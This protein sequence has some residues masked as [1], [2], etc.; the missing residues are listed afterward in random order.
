MSV[1]SL[2]VGRKRKVKMLGAQS[3]PALYNPMDGSLTSQAPLS[4]GFSRQE[5]WSGGPFPSGDIPDSGMEPASLAPPVLG[6]RFFA[7]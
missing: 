1:L 5:Y 6:G 7:S 3:F 2:D 4:L